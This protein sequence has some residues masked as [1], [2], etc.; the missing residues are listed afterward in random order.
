LIS[1]SAQYDA[2]FERLFGAYTAPTRHY[3]NASHISDC[4]QLA[5]KFRDHFTDRRAVAT[6]LFFHDAVYDPA[7][8]DNEARSADLADQ[9]LRAMNEPEE[10]I[11]RVHHLILDTR[12]TAPPTTPDGQYLADIDLS[13]LG[14]DTETFDAYDRA[15]RLEYAHVP[16]EAYRTGRAAVLRSFLARETIYH[17][18][19]FRDQYEQMARTNL[20]RAIANLTAS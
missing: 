20:A 10:V 7:R 1:H 9:D 3:H 6:A 2:I 17:T 11:A 14:R 18:P 19:Q 5:D 8:S 12:H 16:D 15:I 4:L 13:I